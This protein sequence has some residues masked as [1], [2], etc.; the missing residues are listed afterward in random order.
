MYIDAIAIQP[1]STSSTSIPHKTAILSSTFRTVGLSLATNIFRPVNAV[2]KFT[3]HP[4]PTAFKFSLTAGTVNQKVEPFPSVLS[5]PIWPPINSTNCLEIAR[6][7]PVPPYFLVVEASTWVKDW[8]SFFWSPGAIPIPVSLTLNSRKSERLLPSFNG[9]IFS[10]NF[11]SPLAVNNPGILPVETSITT[12]PTSVNLIALLIKLVSICR[13]RA[14][15]P[16]I[17]SGTSLSI[18]ATNS[19]PF[20][21]AG[22]ANK[23][24]TS[25]RQILR[26][27]SIVSKRISP[28]SSLERSRIS[29]MMDSKF[30]PLS[31][32]VC[33]KSSCSGVSCV[34]SS[35]SVIPITPFIGV[36]I[37]WLIFA[38]NS[39][40]I[41]DASRA[42]SRACCA[43]SNK[44][45]CWMAIA[46]CTL[47]LPSKSTSESVQARGVLHWWATSNP[48]KRFWHFSKLPI[49]AA[50]R[51]SGE[52]S[53]TNS[54]LSSPI[55][56][57]TT[58]LALTCKLTR[59]SRWISPKFA[60]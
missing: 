13:N 39:D 57:G 31:F 49:G 28:A 60:V 38:K 12:S 53:V 16:L 22:V 30:C 6:P 51:V 7:K 47:N 26:S 56:I 36:R 10:K 46:N 14:A 45:D 1:F 52:S 37:S 32:S 33:T 43:C 9:W 58:K 48:H 8:N 17:R 4:V 3:S 24:S 34:F 55:K 5:T 42:T 25:S 27:N 41:R 40:F 29:L 2:C 35:K 50:I 44:V 23:S 15:S 11:W 19:I 54:W 59:K 21:C 20:S 18:S